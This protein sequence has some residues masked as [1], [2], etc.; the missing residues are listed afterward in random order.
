MP[1]NYDAIFTNSHFL[2]ADGAVIFQCDRDRQKWPWLDLPPAH[3]IVVQ[4]ANFWACVETGK[5]RGTLDPTKWSALTYTKWEAGEKD[6]GRISHGLAD[7]PPGAPQKD[8]P[9]FRLTFFDQA[10]K[11]VCRMVG[12][13]V[14]FQTRDFESWRDASKTEEKLYQS[15][16]KFNYAPQEALGVKSDIERFV[17]PLID[18]DGHSATALVTKENGFMPAHPY[19]SGSGDHVNANHLADT[20]FQFA[21]LAFGKPL[22]CVGGEITFKHYVEL[23]KP[24]TL[25]AKAI[26]ETAISITIVQDAKHC[27]DMTL[28]FAV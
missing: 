9:G 12:T 17:S 21:H 2:T 20:G 28:N 13:G 26:E 24:F 3:P 22:E 1:N 27:T 25:D 8:R 10:G 15:M 16:D 14:V 5:T 7:S 23:G 19:H 11:L 6:A 4:T 18:G